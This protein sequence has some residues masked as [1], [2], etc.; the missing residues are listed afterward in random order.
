[1]KDYFYSLNR[2]HIWPAVAAG[3]AAIGGIASNSSDRSRSGEAHDWAKDDAQ[4]E[5]RW[6]E[7]MSNSAHQREVSDLRKAGL[8]PILSATGGG[9][10]PTGSVGL[11]SIDRAKGVDVGSPVDK[12]LAAKMNQSQ[13]SLM[14]V[15]KEQIS[16]AADA[17]RAQARKTNKEAD[18]LAP[19][20]FLMERI[21]EAIRSGAKFMDG[22]DTKRDKNSHKQELPNKKPLPNWGHEVDLDPT[23]GGRP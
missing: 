11:P 20:S 19:K 5:R 15:Q 10:A 21:D 8:N 12:Y 18:I 6:Q 16:S 7:Q 1:M 14:E 9:G 3:I 13:T 2:H 4:T 22:T 23:K 17:N